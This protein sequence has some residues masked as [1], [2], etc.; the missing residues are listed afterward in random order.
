MNI[1]LTAY[2]WP[3]IYRASPTI[4]F[5]WGFLYVDNSVDCVHALY[6]FIHIYAT[7]LRDLLAR[8]LHNGKPGAFQDVV[9]AVK[10]DPTH[11]WLAKKL[12]GKRATP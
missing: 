2:T 10:K 9:L 3:I 12:I 5:N 8:V 4:C 1:G 6:D 11:E 7:R